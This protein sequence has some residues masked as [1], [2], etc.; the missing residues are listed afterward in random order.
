MKRFLVLAVLAILITFCMI[1][2]A[3]AKTETFTREYTYN[4]GEADSKL[5]SRV[6]SLEQVKRLLL[7]ELGTFLSSHTE[8]RNF[9]LTKD[10]VV[11]YTAGTVATIIIE[12]RWNGLEY[13]VKASIKAD[14]DQVAKAI[15]DIRKDRDSAEELQQLRTQ[16]NDALRELDRLKKELADLKKNSPNQDKAKIANVHK[17]YD[18]AVAGLSA[19]E[20]CEKGLALAKEKKY[21]EAI[22]QLNIAV[23]ADPKAIAP[24]G[25]RGQVYMKAKEYDKAIEDFNRVLTARPNHPLALK[26]RGQAYYQR[27]DYILATGDFKLASQ[28][29]K[30]DSKLMIDLGRTYHVTKHYEDAINS[31]TR[32]IEIDP[33]FAPAYMFRFFSYQSMRMSEKAQKDLEK[34]AHLGD[35]KAKEMLERNSGRPH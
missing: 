8:V 9:Q 5:S 16:T 11:T 23:Q 4:A 6:I 19:K 34:A 15:N 7:E 10:D 35:P 12:E 32:A 27:K 30:G 20:I 31:F 1:A 24:Y 33:S 21:R 18:Q 22:E 14:P 3:N 2:S 28:L 29:V 13:Y 26:H 17:E 25:L